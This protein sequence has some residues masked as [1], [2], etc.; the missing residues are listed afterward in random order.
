MGRDALLKANRELAAAGLRHQFKRRGPSG[1]VITD[2]IISE[3]PISAEEAE[4][5][6]LAYVREDL[7]GAPAP[8]DN[9][10]SDRA[11]ENG[12]TRPG[13]GSTVRR[14]TVA[15]STGASTPRGVANSSRSEERRV[16]KE[17]PV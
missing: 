5:E 17:C 9:S 14:F 15:R 1:Q 7:G 13:G 8:V 3:V 10:G 2:T 16:G 11:P 6:W 4:A 12:A